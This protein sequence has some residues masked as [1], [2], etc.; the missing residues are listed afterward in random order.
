MK[1]EIPPHLVLCEHCK[2]RFPLSWIAE[3]RYGACKFDGFYFC[4]EKCRT[5]YLSIISLTRSHNQQTISGGVPMKNENAMPL[6]L[7]PKRKESKRDAPQGR[8]LLLQH[9]LLQKTL[10]D[11]R[12]IGNI[13]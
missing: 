10:R 3:K 2:T 5:G 1:S 12:R 11:T 13:R 9:K 4:G 7:L 8:A 6:R